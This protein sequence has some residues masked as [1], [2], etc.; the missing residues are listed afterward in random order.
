[1]HTHFVQA[2]HYDWFPRLKNFSNLRVTP[3]SKVSIGDGTNFWNFFKKVSLFHYFVSSWD[4][5]QQVTEL[6]LP[7]LW[8]RLWSIFHILNF[9]NFLST[10]CHSIDT[11]PAQGGYSLSETMGCIDTSDITK[12]GCSLSLQEI[13]PWRW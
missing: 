13:Q 3:L 8:P 6:G 11:G 4:S 10:L 9:L 5:S 7:W 1:M 12:Q 2:Y